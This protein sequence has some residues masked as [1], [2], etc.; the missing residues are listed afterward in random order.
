MT[1]PVSDGGHRFQEV[2]LAHLSPAQGEAHG[3]CRVSLGSPHQMTAGGADLWA[4][5]HLSQGS[6]T[7]GQEMENA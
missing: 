6:L 2:L 3:L 7:D 5:L 4:D 1:V